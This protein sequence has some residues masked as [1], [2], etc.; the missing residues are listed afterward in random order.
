MLVMIDVRCFG[1]HACHATLRRSS[2]SLATPVWFL[3]CAPLF[4]FSS[5]WL[6][7]CRFQKKRIL[8]IAWLCSLSPFSSLPL[9]ALSFAS[10]RSR[11]TT[12]AGRTVSGIWTG[13]SE[14]VVLFLGMGGVVLWVRC[15]VCL[16]VCVGLLSFLRGGFLLSFRGFLSLFSWVSFPFFVYISFLFLV[17]VFFTF[18]VCVSFFPRVDFF[19]FLRVYVRYVEI[20]YLLSFYALFACYLWGSRAC[21][22]MDTGW[23]SGKREKRRI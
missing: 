9:A 21:G 14:L 12:L 19:S 7:A 10:G 22:W 4:C 3:N 1:R 5:C 6:G 18:F 15:V 8:R 2:I 17:C 13:A 20:D 16:C 11:Y 23:R